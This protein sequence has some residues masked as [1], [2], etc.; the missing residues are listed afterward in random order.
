MNCLVWNYRGAAKKSFKTSLRNFIKKYKISLVAILEP[1]ISG[2]IAQKKIKQLGFNNSVIEDAV[3]FSGGIW[4]LWKEEFCNVTILEKSS[5]IIHVSCSMNQGLDFYLTVV[6]ANLREEVREELWMDLT[7]ISSSLV[8]PWAMMGD[9]NEIASVKEKKGGAPIWA[10]KELTLPGGGPSGFILIEFSKGWTVC[11][12]ANW[13]T[14]F[15]EATVRSLPRLNSYH[16]PLLLSLYPKNQDWRERPFRFLASWQDH[17]TFPHFLKFVWKPNLNIRISLSNLVPSL[18][19]WNKRVFRCIQLRKYYLLKKIQDNQNNYDTDRDYAQTELDIALQCELNRVMDH[20]E[21]LW[22][23]KARCNWIANGDRN[24]TFY[25]TTIIRRARNRISELKNDQGYMVKEESELILLIHSF[26]K[27]L[28]SEEDDC[29]PWFNTTHTWHVL[30]DSELKVMQDPITDS[31]IREVWNRPEMVKELNKTHLVLIPKLAKPEKINQFRPIALCS[32]IYKGISKLIVGKLKPLLDKLIS[33]QQVSFVPN[34]QIQDNI[35]IAQEMVHSMSRMKGKRGFFAIKIDLE[36]AYD[37]MSWKFI[38]EVLS[39]AN[40]LVSLVNLIM[41]C[42]SS[43]ELEIFWNG[44]Q[45][46]SI[47]PS[48]GLRQGDPLSPYIFVLCMEK[49]S[50][51][52]TDSLEK[53]EWKPKK[54]GKGGPSI[55][56]LLFADDLMLFGEADSDQIRI[57]MSCLNKFGSMSGQKVSLKKSSIFFSKNVPQDVVNAIVEIS[58]FAHTKNLGRYLGYKRKHGRVSK[59]HHGELMDRVNNMLQGWEKQ[60]LSMAGRITLAKSVIS[61]IPMFNMQ[62]SLLPMGICDEIEKLQ[63]KFRWGDTDNQR[64]Y[65]AIGWDCLKLA[66]DQGGLGIIDLR[67]QNEAFLQK[68]AWNITQFPLQAWVQV[69]FSKYSRKKDLMKEVSCKTYDSHLW[70]SLCRIWP[71]MLNNTVWQIGNGRKIKFWKDDWVGNSSNLIS[72]TAAPPTDEDSDLTINHSNFCSEEGWNMQF[73]LSHFDQNTV[74]LI[75][76]IPYPEDGVGEDII[77]WKYWNPN[78]SIVKMAYCSQTASDSAPTDSCWNRVWKW[79]GKERFKILLWKMLHGRM[80][81]KDRVTK[82]SGGSNNCHLCPDQ[83]EEC[84]HVFRDCFMAKKVWLLPMFYPLPQGFFNP[85]SFKEWLCLNLNI[86]SCSGKD[87]RDVFF[88]V[89]NSLW[90]WRNK[91]IH[92]EGYKRPVDP[93]IPLA[94]HIEEIRCS[95]VHRSREVLSIPALIKPEKWTAPNHGYFKLNVDGAVNGGQAACGGLIRGRNGDWIDGFSIFLGSCS[96]L[97]AEL[98]AVYHG[99]V[100]AWN[101]NWKQI[102]LESDS[103]QA[104]SLLTLRGNDTRK[105][106]LVAKIRVFLQKEWNVQLNGISRKANMCVDWIAKKALDDHPLGLSPISSPRCALLN[107]LAA[108]ILDPGLDT[109]AN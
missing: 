10:V 13:R 37:W 43:S 65:H 44:T 73:L 22:F 40:F 60:C 30:E 69:L 82:W 77:V 53:K 11:A 109:A 9:F 45:A 12:N 3:G 93:S 58:G 74:N 75:L 86:N 21:A 27:K 50:H 26:F 88:V 61:T 100:F 15:E 39:E 90:I 72:I 79:K 5:Q 7:R 1:R 101:H 91:E 8:G 63:R 33:P 81:T 106:P 20:E 67:K 64:K 25:H 104:L 84:L 42:I 85:I 99:L 107:L 92:E 94:A 29:R 108:D 54:A 68:G 56:H 105:L 89:C 2:A 32:V 16:N 6:Y 19:S 4:L 57:V 28:F 47:S 34:R 17:V 78:S 87:W 52:I 66:K 14:T 35:I 102:T 95:F 62:S 59:L 97:M 70:K 36:K 51:L 76:A 23:Q 96:P 55:S 48:R 80:L 71:K 41:Q 103:S 18:I 38:H 49:L 24:T 31:Q 46:G 83:V 98:W